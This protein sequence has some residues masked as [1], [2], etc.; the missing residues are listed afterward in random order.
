[1]GTAYITLVLAPS[2]PLRAAVRGVF[3]LCYA[4]SMAPE[5]TKAITQLW[6]DESGDSGFKF[7]RGSSVHMVVAVVYM[8]ASDASTISEA[9]TNMK[10]KLGLPLEFEFKFSRTSN[11]F[12][13]EFFDALLRHKWEYKAI[14]VNKRRLRAPALTGHPHQLYCELVRRLLYDND[15]PL[16]KAVLTIDEAVA[17]IHYREFNAVLKQYVSKNTVRKIRQVKSNKE[18]M[19]QLTDMIAGSIFRKYEKN[20]SRYYDRLLSKQ[21]ILMDF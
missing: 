21:R 3:H 17:K 10:T 8:V 6:A 20:D 4:V 12:R 2:V 14:V 18:Q 19:I 15:P 7:N 16:A 5:Q 11:K 9:I 1:M 13:E